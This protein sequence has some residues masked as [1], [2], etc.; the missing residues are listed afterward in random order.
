MD[1]LIIEDEIKTAKFLGSLLQELRPHSRILATLQSVSSS[2]Q[3]FANQ[4][5]PDLI[6]MD[7][8]LADGICFDIFEKTNISAPVIFCTAFNDYATQAFKNNGIDYILKPFT[9]E[10]IQEALYKTERPSDKVRNHNFPNE[11]LMS[12]LKTLSKEPGKKN[13]LIYDQNKY[14]NVPTEKIAYFYRGEDGVHLVTEE[15]KKYAVAESLDELHHL[16]GITFFYRI[17]RQY[18]VA[19]KSIMEVQHYFDR[20]LV[21]KLQCPVGEKLIVGREKATNFLDWLRDR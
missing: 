9:K 14:I 7:I 8:Q 10:D 16:V 11:E 13:F 21:V 19:F 3:W 6:F 2:V 4:E 15:N 12:V 20:K 18:L 1:I 5:Q 17:N